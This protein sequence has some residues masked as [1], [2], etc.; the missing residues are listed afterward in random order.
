MEEIIRGS[1]LLGRK[2]DSEDG[3]RLPFF[4]IIRADT[5][6]EHRDP[7]GQVALSIYNNRKVTIVAVNGH[8]VSDD[9]M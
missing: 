9:L 7:G 3:S 5:W 6:T 8:A 1:V 2:E 4:F